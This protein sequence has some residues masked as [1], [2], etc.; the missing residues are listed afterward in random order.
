MDGLSAAGS[1]IALYQLTCD[2]VSLCWKCRRGLKHAAKDFELL[3][4]ELTAL[5]T[6][7]NGFREA[8]DQV[9]HQVS[10]PERASKTLALKQL[11]GTNGLFVSCEKR[12]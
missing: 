12:T 2:I 10:D 7:L 9:E 5:S 3:I 8:A 11:I 1:A 6:V 4:T